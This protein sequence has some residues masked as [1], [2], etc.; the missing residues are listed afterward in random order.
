MSTFDQ[1]L[2]DL[3]ARIDAAKEQQRKLQKELEAAEEEKNH[4][5]AAIPK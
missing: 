2:S 5:I 4:L 1:Q 3:E